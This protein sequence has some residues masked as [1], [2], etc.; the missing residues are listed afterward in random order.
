MDIEIEQITSQE[1]PQKLQNNNKA[2]TKGNPH[3]VAG[4][5][6]ESPDSGNNNSSNSDIIFHEDQKDGD[7]GMDDCDDVSDTMRIPI[8]QPILHHILSFLHAK[9]AA[10]M[11]T[12]SKVWDSA[13]NSLPYLDFGEIFWW[14]KDLNVVMDQTLASRKKHKISMQRFSLW[15]SYYACLSYDDRWIKILIACNI[16]ELNLR[17]EIHYYRGNFLYGSLPVAIFAAKSLNVLSLHGFNIELPADD[18]MI[19]LSSLRELHLSFVFLDEQFIKAMCTS[20]CNLEHLSL[21]YFNG[22]TSFQVGGTLPKLKMINL[23]KLE[24][25][26][27]LLQL[28]D[29]VAINLEKLSISNK[30]YGNINVVRITACKAL[31]NLY[32]NCVDITDNWLEELFYSLKNLEKFDLICC[33]ALKTMKITSERLKQLRVVDC[34]NLI[35]VELDTPNLIKFHCFNEKFK[36]FLG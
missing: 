1:N 19:N 25:P 30:F 18:G 2:I 27:S 34:H 28:V 8:L 14:S 24:P 16:K 26:D 6:S 21:Q 33:K 20:C 12:L 15:L 13:W 36:V 29:I 9:H 3:T 10:R 22:L 35:A 32:L 31:K 5:T 11:S 7:D 17:V 4:T 23:V